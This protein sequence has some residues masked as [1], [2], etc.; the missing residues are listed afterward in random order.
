MEQLA[1]YQ[2]RIGKFNGTEALIKDAL[3]TAY[4][5]IETDWSYMSEQME[6]LRAI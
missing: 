6:M 1:D 2:Q 4:V 3:G 5:G